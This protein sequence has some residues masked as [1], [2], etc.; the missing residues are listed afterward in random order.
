MKIIATI[1]APPTNSIFTKCKCG[2]NV[3][4]GDVGNVVSDVVDNVVETA[5]VD[6]SGKSNKQS[7]LLNYFQTN[8]KQ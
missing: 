2:D 6:E 5:V 1:T 7:K 4:D 8:F 3:D